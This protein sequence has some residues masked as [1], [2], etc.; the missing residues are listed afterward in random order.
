M[1]WTSAL[2]IFFLI[3]VMSAFFV[4]PFGLRTLDE[5]GTVRVP[6]QVDSAPANFDPRRI[7]RRATVLAVILFALFY[8]N[9]THGWI[10]AD[11][12]DVTGGMGKVPPLETPAGN[13]T[14]PSTAR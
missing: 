3:W 9:Y 6:G 7:A 5:D 13:S 8:A 14:P 10:T 2:A 12:L 4:M 1:Q 11:D